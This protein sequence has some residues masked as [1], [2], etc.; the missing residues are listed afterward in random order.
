MEPSSFKIIKDKMDDV[1]ILNEATGLLWD[2]KEKRF[3]D[4]KLSYKFE[5]EET[6]T[7][8][9]SD[10]IIKLL[11]L[12]YETKLSK[13]LY[14]NDEYYLKNRTR[15][16]LVKHLK[17]N[18]NLALKLNALRSILSENIIKD[19][20]KIFFEKQKNNIEKLVFEK[21]GHYL[22][23]YPDNVISCVFKYEPNYYRDIFDNSF[24]FLNLD[25]LSGF[26]LRLK[27]LEELLKQIIFEED[28]LGKN[29]NLNIR[30]I[31]KEEKEKLIDDILY[32]IIKIK[33]NKTN[34]EIKWTF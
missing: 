30:K 14:Y 5:L 4:K 12:Y 24:D 28:V 7:N 19:I 20:P 26:D 13:N 10:E 3:R 31:Y 21:Y 25:I 27:K 32:N 18:I 1:Y 29:E 17:V 15:L 9:N 34:K 23:D 33:I 2:D 22:E 16:G 8:K 11:T 6:F